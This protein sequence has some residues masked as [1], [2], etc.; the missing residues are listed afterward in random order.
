MTVPGHHF[1][2][3]TVESDPAFLTIF[4]ERH[5]EPGAQH[6]AGRIAGMDDKWPVL[7][8][9]HVERC[10]SIEIGLSFFSEVRF[11]RKTGFRGKPYDAAV[12]QGQIPVLVLYA[13]FDYTHTAI[14]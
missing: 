8:G 11:V 9:L 7:I 2:L 6:L 13:P 3:S 1:Y 5:I 12:G 10:S 4:I 14:G